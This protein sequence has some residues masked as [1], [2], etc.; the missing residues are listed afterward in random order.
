MRWLDSITDTMDMSLFY[1]V[2][3]SVHRFP[4]VRLG[5]KCEM[6]NK[7][8]IG[9]IMTIKQT[10]SSNSFLGHTTPAY[11]LC[12]GQQHHPACPP[13][14]PTASAKSRRGGKT[15]D[16]RVN[17]FLWGRRAQATHSVAWRASPP[18]PLGC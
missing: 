6:F 13:S 7:H 2:A 8:N 5:M 1:S 16:P 15:T 11:G 12:P 10:T 4:L 9:K 17:A 18:F 14:V 3:I